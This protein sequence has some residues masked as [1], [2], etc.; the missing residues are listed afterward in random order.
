MYFQMSLCDWFAFAIELSGDDDD[1]KGGLLNFCDAG[2]PGKN[3]TFGTNG[4]VVPWQIRL[5]G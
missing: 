4:T 5:C 1:D 3:G 2:G